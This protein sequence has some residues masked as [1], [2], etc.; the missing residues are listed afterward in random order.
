MELRIQVVVR[1]VGSG[2][3][4]SFVLLNEEQAQDF[5]PFQGLPEAIHG[6]MQCTLLLE[7]RLQLLRLLEEKRPIDPVELEK[8]LMRM[9]QNQAQMLM[10]QTLERCLSE[11]DRIQGP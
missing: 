10:P 8:N 7:G 4:T 9:V 3:Q 1:K 6:M 5:G 2:L 11:L